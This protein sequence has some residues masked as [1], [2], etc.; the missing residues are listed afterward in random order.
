M[1]PASQNNTTTS[2]LRG[3][4]LLFLLL[5]M[6]GTTAEL[7][8]V[9]HTEDTWQLTPLLLIAVCFAVLAWHAARRGRASVRALQLVMLLFIASGFA[10]GYLHMKAKIE[11]QLEV[12]PSLAGTA[13]Y[14][15]A[16]ESISP[17]ALAPGMMIYLG[18]LGFAYTWRHP[19]LNRAGEQ[20]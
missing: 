8:L 18:L 10:G 15:K 11:F 3:F 5:G 4:F 1:P 12:N 6:L 7:L 17:P 16:L 20:R 19:A 9:G 13:L 2:R 14:K